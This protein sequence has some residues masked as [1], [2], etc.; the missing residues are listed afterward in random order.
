MKIKDT[1]TFPHPVLQKYSNDY[2]SGEFDA[3][4]SVNT[5]NCEISFLLTLTEETLLKSIISGQAKCSIFLSCKDT[6]ITDSHDI[7][8][9]SRVTNGKFNFKPENFRGLVTIRAI[10]Y[11]AVDI[12]PYINQNLH[13][14]LSDEDWKLDKGSILA[15]STE[16][17]FKSIPAKLQATETI[18]IFSAHDA[19]EDNEIL[20]DL[21]SDKIDIRVNRE[22]LNS[23]TELRSTR[24]GKDILLNSIYLPAVMEALW[25]IAEEPT[26]YEERSWYPI[27]KMKCE[28]LDIDFES[29]N[30]LR[31]AQ[32]ILKNPL[33]RILKNMEI[34]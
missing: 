5:R 7:K 6:Y 10:V 13:P 2:I 18:F 19:I 14:E 16:S 3:S 31:D 23:I 21:N 9:L 24:R 12:H 8:I 27:F 32:K 25:Q 22:T 1:S 4:F 29:I 11:S 17:R 33:S 15:F 30:P 34:V 26:I 28:S 20:V